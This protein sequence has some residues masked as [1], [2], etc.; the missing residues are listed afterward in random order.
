MCIRDSVIPG[1]TPNNINPPIK[2]AVPPDPGIPNNKVGISAPPSL[3]LELD[4]G[5]ITPLMSPFPK[6]SLFLTV[7]FA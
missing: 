3:E 6:F 2:I 7:V 4:S 5:P 1:S